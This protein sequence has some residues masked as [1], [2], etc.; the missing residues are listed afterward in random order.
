MNRIFLTLLA[1]SVLLVAF[2]QNAQAQNTPQTCI[3]IYM[4]SGEVKAGTFVRTG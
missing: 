1:A 3:T 4:K 2:L